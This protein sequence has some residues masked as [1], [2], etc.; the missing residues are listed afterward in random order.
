MNR[1]SESILQEEHV[2]LHFPGFILYDNQETYTI[3][4]QC[5]RI[6]PYVQSL[7]GPMCSAHLV[8][9]HTTVNSV[10]KYDPD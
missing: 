7:N 9:E 1:S 6:C 2:L 3:C 5:G 8:V 10:D 4:V